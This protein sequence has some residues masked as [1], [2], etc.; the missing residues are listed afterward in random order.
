MYSTKIDWAE[1]S[2]NPV[3]GC[4]HGCE[5]C[6]AR[7]MVNR[8]GRDSACGAGR[9]IGTERRPL[10]ELE[11]RVY[12]QMEDGSPKFNP[13][14][15]RFAPTLHRYRLDDPKAWH[16]QRT[17]F[18]CSMADLFGDWVPETWIRDV[19]AACK[20]APRH[21]YLFL[22]KN[23]RRYNELLDDHILPA[24][25]DNYWYGVTR[26]GKDSD[27]EYDVPMSGHAFLSVEPI[28]SP[29]ERSTL[30]ALE[31]WEW[32]IVGAESGDRKGKV[33]PRKEW[34][35]EIAERCRENRIPIFMKTSIRELMGADFRQEYPWGEQ[36]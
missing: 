33:T 6:Y 14:P 21:R 15:F 16:K 28:L 17:I 8:F 12:E 30:N 7:N 32:V 25:A 23:P 24:R 26:T 11:K 36:R 10:Y 34:I 13:Y 9:N 29:M 22:T 35:D 1:A 19:F 2:W 20:A 4:N 3:S 18:A 27:R 31:M 5:Y